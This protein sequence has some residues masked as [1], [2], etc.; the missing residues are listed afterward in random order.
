MYYK[1]HRLI[2]DVLGSRYFLQRIVDNYLDQFKN[3]IKDS[4]YTDPKTIVVK[5][6]L[7]NL[8][9]HCR[10]GLDGP[11]DMKP[12][13]WFHLTVQMDQNHTADKAF[14]ISY[15]QTHSPTPATHIPTPL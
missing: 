10:N 15:Q 11:S 9:G 6:C 4:G 7:L 1:T 2:W 3:L 8:D 5:F 14:H 12:E 13:A